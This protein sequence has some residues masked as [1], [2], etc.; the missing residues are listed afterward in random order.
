MRHFFKYLA[1]KKNFLELLYVNNKNPLHFH[2][3]FAEEED[4]KKNMNSELQVYKNILIF[5]CAT[6]EQSCYSR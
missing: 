2:H 6:C 5:T 3:D 4:N 1:K